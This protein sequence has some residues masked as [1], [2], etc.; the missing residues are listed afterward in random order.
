MLAD[1]RYLAKAHLPR[2]S[3]V[4]TCLLESLSST[5]QDKEF[6][7]YSFG[8]YYEIDMIRIVKVLSSHFI[9]T[10]TNCFPFL[11]DFLHWNLFYGDFSTHVPSPTYHLDLE[12]HYLFLYFHYRCH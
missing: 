4:P 12:D 3:F 2:Q 11:L 8:K 6:S 9:L 7:D 5:Y 10:V 1:F